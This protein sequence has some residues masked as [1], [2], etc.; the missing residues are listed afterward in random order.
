MKK[1]NIAM[2]ASAVFLS[3][4]CVQTTYNKSITVTKDA[5]GNII[6]TVE[7]ESVTQPGQG[8]PIKLKMLKDV[9]P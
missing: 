8:W 7:T 3:T 2:L 5:H 6:Q 4:G 1:I 9:Q